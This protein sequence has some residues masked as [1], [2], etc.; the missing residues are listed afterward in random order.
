M[1]RLITRLVF[2]VVPLAMIACA[3]DQNTEVT[4]VYTANSTIELLEPAI[5]EINFDYNY[6]DVFD[7]G[8]TVSL[9]VKVPPQLEYLKNSAE[10]NEWGSNDQYVN[11]FARKCADGTT[12]LAFV[13]DDNDLDNAYSPDNADAQL[14][15]TLVGVRRGQEVT[16]EATAS[17]DNVPYGCREDFTADDSETIEVQ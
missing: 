2:C 7:D 9:V 5:F 13:F 6:N 8:D 16:V 3:E 12:Y 1:Q 15:I 11:P 10:L 14:S 4:E 17:S